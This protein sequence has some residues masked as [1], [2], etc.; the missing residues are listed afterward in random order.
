MWIVCLRQEKHLFIQQSSLSFTKLDQI[1]SCYGEKIFQI[2]TNLKIDLVANF[3]KKKMYI[4]FNQECLISCFIQITFQGKL[5]MLI[6]PT[7][8]PKLIKYS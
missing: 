8:V 1:I 5:A 7:I 6:F 2:F 4:C 3:T